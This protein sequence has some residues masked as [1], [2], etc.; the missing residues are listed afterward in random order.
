[1]K[2]LQIT[3]GILK[4]KKITDE[5][6][7]TKV[8]SLKAKPKGKANKNNKNPNAFAPK[9]KNKKVQK[10]KESV[11][12]VVKKDIGKEI[13]ILTWLQKPLKKATR[14]NKINCYLLEVYVVN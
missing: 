3:E 11:S 6:N 2:D 1:M 7:V 5:A 8:G 13:E 12:T 9:K 14:I 4:K 10:P